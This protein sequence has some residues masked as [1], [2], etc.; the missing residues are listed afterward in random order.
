MKRPTMRF[1]Q[2][3]KHSAPVLNKR[4]AL[5]LATT[6]SMLGAAA[7]AQTTPS[8]TPKELDAIQKQ[9]EQSKAQQDALKAKAAQ[10]DKEIADL[11]AEAIKA[12]HEVQDTESQVTELE[13]TLAALSDEEKEKSAALEIE[14]A[15]LTQAVLAL[16]RLSTQPREA[17]LFSSE[18][19]IDAARTARLLGIITPE[20]DARARSLQSDL[21]ELHEMR[22]QMAQERDQLAKAVTKLAK[23]NDRLSDLIR[24]KGQVQKS[25]LAESASAQNKLEKLAGQA[26]N[27]QDLIERLNKAKAETG[28]VVAAQPPSQQVASLA[29]GNTNAAPTT[30]QRM[31]PPANLRN[32][33]EAAKIDAKNPIFAPARGRILTHFGDP[34]DTGGASKGLVLETRPGAQIVAPFDGRIAFEGPFRSYGQ[35]LIIEHGGGYHT[36]LAGLDR[37]DAVVGQWLLAGEPVGSMAPVGAPQGS[38]DVSP[39][40]RPKLYLELRRNG[41]PVD[42]VPWFSTAEIKNDSQ[43]VNK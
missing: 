28:P 14:R 20:L 7:Y 16:Q 27:L 39:A 25:T 15:R 21:N 10:L 5:F 6:L 11:Q 32:F 31:Q 12:A 35:I 33:P 43:A 1:A 29:P 34:T 22:E 13:D 3:T 36:V 38:G 18:T 2:G 42:P 9:I 19:P 8:P 30:A 23:E 41:Q 24:K 40:G 26:K 4:R 37:V 17:L